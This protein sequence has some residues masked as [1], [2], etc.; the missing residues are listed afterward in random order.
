MADRPSLEGAHSI[1][2]DMIVPIR[3]RRCSRTPFPMVGVFAMTVQLKKARAGR[4][5]CGISRYLLPHNLSCHFAS[6]FAIAGW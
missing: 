6:V 4:L 5:L 1:N 3:I 2:N